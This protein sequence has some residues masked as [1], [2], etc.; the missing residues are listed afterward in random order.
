MAWNAYSKG[1]GASPLR[2]ID[3]SP[4]NGMQAPGAQFFSFEV[5]KGTRVVT[6]CMTARHPTV[7]TKYTARWDFSIE[8]L[9][10]AVNISRS[11]ASIYLPP[12]SGGCK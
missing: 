5:E 10:S 11:G 8:A 2:D 12:S 7:G 3:V 4:L 9:D 1:G 6:F